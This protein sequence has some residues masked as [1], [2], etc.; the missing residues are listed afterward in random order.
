[1]FKIVAFASST[2]PAEQDYVTEQLAVLKQEF[3]TIETEVS[4]E[5]DNRLTLYCTH[6][7]LPCLMMFYNNNHKTHKH[8]KL[9]HEQAKT[10]V[11]S[12]SSL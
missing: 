12:Y 7:R 11:R 1:M 5:T 9:T 10:W 3:P 6:N 4:D 8:A 2:R